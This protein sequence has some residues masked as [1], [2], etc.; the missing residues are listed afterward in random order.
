MQAKL[1]FARLGCYQL[2]DHQLRCLGYALPK[3]AVSTAALI[4]RQ[5][6][7]WRMREQVPREKLS[8]E[9]KELVLEKLSWKVRELVLREKMSW[10]MRKLAKGKLC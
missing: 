2:A 4:L 8:R 5:M 9:I 1:Q 10:M 7:S 6:P 3:P